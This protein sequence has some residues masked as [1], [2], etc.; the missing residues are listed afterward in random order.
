MRPKCKKC[1]NKAKN[2][3][4]RSQQGP[5]LKVLRPPRTLLQKGRS[6]SKTRTMWGW[7]W[8]KTCHAGGRTP[9]ALGRSAGL[10]ETAR[11]SRHRKSRPNKPNLYNVMQGQIQIQSQFPLIYQNLSKMESKSSKK[12]PKTLRKLSQT[13]SSKINTSK[14]SKNAVSQ[15]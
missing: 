15:N 8:L 9:R 11:G 4:K 7:C 14:T 1:K 2:G 3:E 10:R 12:L 5:H 13:P 6:P